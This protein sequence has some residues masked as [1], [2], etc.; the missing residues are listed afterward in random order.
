MPGRLSH[1]MTLLVFLSLGISSS[2]NPREETLT[3]AVRFH[4]TEGVTM[5]LKDQEMDMWV[6]PEDIEKTVLPEVNR[7]WKQA[8]IFFVIERNQRQPL[9]APLNRK[10]LI[11]FVEAAKRGDDEAKERQR[12]ASIDALLDPAQR[13]PTAMNVHL[14]PFISSTYQ[15]YAKLG[16]NHAVVAVW[17]D[18]ASK[19]KKPPVRTLLVEPEPMKVGSLAR[20]IAHELGH[21]LELSHPPKDIP[22]PTPRLMGGNIHGYGLTHAEIDKARAFARKHGAI[23]GDR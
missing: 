22:N 14:Y 7:I 6:T 18:K 5:N 1:F 23:E 21:N 11:R 17:T 16:G 2:A 13:H 15:G 19:G 20:T 3:L 10:E 8:N 9:L 12:T 4:L